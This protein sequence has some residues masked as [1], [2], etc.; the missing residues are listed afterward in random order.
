MRIHHATAAKAKK[1]QIT[2]TVEDNEIVATGKTGTRLASGLQGNKVLEDAITRQ[3]GKPAK[4]AVKLLDTTALGKA[5]ARTAPKPVVP[6]DPFEEA[7]KEDGWKKSRWGFSKEGEESIRAASWQ[8]LCEAAGIEVETDEEGTGT[9]SVVKAKYKAKY[10][11][12]KNR[13]G[14]EL[15]HRMNE[16]C[17]REDDA[18]DMRI[19]LDALR[20]FA[21]ANECW[22]E[23]YASLKSR[24]GTFNGGMAMMNVN[25]RLRAR[26]RKIAKEQERAFD[27]DKD[28]SWK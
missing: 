15:S 3:T 23:S 8:A 10:K 9:K 19:D 22:V 7:A 4:G 27:I 2:L 14:D 28:I 17:S 24:V 18:G 25:N 1:F 5:I 12:T 13:C 6:A 26:L 21:K 16:H 11:P 20:K